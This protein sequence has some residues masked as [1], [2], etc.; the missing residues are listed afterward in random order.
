MFSGK[1]SKFSENDEKQKKSTFKKALDS[2]FISLHSLEQFY[3]K[4]ITYLVEKNKRVRN[5]LLWTLLLFFSSLKP[6]C[7]CWRIYL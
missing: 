4:V 7:F 5:L 2:W 6:F 1:D 3:W